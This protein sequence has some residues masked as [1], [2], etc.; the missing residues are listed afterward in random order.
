MGISMKN[1]DEWSEK[2]KNTSN[3]GGKLDRGINA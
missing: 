3:G 1:V 2:L